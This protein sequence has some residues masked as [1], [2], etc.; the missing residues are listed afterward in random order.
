[1]ARLQERFELDAAENFL[2]GRTLTIELSL[3]LSFLFLLSALSLLS[4][5]HLPP[6]PLAFHSLIF[7]GARRELITAALFPTGGD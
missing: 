7:S 6:F 1:M 4:L 5:E 3:L 2:V